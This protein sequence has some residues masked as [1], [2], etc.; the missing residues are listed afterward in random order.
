[1]ASAFAVTRRRSNA[2][3]K[4][5]ADKKATFAIGGCIPVAGSY[6]DAASYEADEP[7]PKDDDLIRRLYMNCHCDPERYERFLQTPRS[8]S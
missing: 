6:E 5:I 8:G 2:I 7:A 3:A 1:M 4:L